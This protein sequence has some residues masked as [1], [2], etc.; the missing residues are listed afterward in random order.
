[1]GNEIQLGIRIT[2][3]GNIA[4]GEVKSTRVEIEKLSASSGKLASDYSGLDK[5]IATTS[6][7]TFKSSEE[8]RKLDG[9]LTS[10]LSTIDPLYRSTRQLDAGNELLHQGLKSGLLSQTQYQSAL[11]SLAE[12]FGVAGVAAGKSALGTAQARRE[13][14]T[15][16]HE[17]I[18][19]NFARM[20]G[21]FMVLASRMGTVGAGA[22][23]MGLAIA[24][25]VGG[26]VYAAVK[27]DEYERT[28]ASLQRQFDG[29]GRGALVAGD[30]MRQMVEQLAMLPGVSKDAAEQIVAAF[31]HVPEVGGPMFQR[32]TG[33]TR[34][35]AAAMGTDGP[36]AA[37]M[38]ADAFAHPAEG[39]K[40]LD[41]QLNFLTADQILLIEKFERQGQIFYADHVVACQHNGPLHQVLELAN[42]ARIIVAQQ[43]L[44]RLPGESPYSL[45]VLPGEDAQE[46]L[47][48]RRQVLAALPERRQHDRDHVD[49]VVEILAE[50]PLPHEGFQVP[51]CRR[52]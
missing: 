37:M 21:S 15:I 17:A 9:R 31:A 45:A 29:S 36:K 22:V 47:D 32:L 6:T 8:F 14:I 38:L 52:Q 19:G 5:A 24:A 51:V 46:V 10:L 49:A 18:S 25:G 28:L 3:D 48:E 42:I 35:F 7:S 2:A 34:D 33:M 4:R 1:M 39:A 11:D 20:P 30:R 50:A 43:R 26:L 23:G 27:A 41:A 16:G 40:K 13:L 44:P 12:K